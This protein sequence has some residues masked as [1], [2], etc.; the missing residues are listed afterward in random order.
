MSVSFT[1]AAELSD[2]NGGGGSRCKGSKRF[3]GGLTWNVTLARVE[4][5]KKT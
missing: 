5:L 2:L 3:A 4:L 1:F